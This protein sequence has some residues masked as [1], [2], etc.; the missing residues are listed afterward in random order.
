VVGYISDMGRE[1]RGYGWGV[2]VVDG[3]VN[4]QSAVLGDR[5]LEGIVCDLMIR[6]AWGVSSSVQA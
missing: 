6:M 5:A 3:Q 2:L 1:M 4:G